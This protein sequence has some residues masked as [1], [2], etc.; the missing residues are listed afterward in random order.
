MGV[1]D[2]IRESFSA[3]VDDGHASLVK[4]IAR[5]LQFIVAWLTLVVLAAWTIT[6]L[7]DTL[8]RTGY[9]DDK[10]IL[11]MLGV[12]VA[13]TLSSLDDLFKR[14]RTLSDD[15]A[16]LAPVQPKLVSRGVTE[17]Y[18]PLLQELKTVPRRHRRIDVLGLTLFTAWDQLEGW[19]SE[20]DTQGWTITLLC[21]D[22]AFAARQVPGIPAAWYDA[23]RNKT[24]EITA[25]RAAKEKDLRQR[26]IKLTVVHYAAF[27]A[28]HGFR[29]GNDALFISSV[30][31]E[32]NADQLA[33]PYHFYDVF[34]AKDRSERAEAY[35][36]LFAN[37]FDHAKR[38][39]APRSAAAPPAP[40]TP[41][42][43]AAGLDSP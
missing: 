20:P 5:G 43:A 15:V 16:E 25:Y 39:A 36:S 19:L 23:A 26:R 35:R 18:G 10:T 32:P 41:G 34:A 8:V 38:T 14:V 21:L 12:L 1:R 27:P 31:W 29:V 4:K 40:S 11:A 28:L 37:W 13:L 2:E 33:K 7:R 42:G 30:H 22:P 6:P 17:V 3:F 24:E 9:F